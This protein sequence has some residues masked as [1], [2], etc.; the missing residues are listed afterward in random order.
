MGGG[1]GK[2][3]NALILFGVFRG[4]VFLMFRHSSGIHYGQTNVGASIS[5]NLDTRQT[6]VHTT[7]RSAHL[8]IIFVRG[9]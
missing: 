7:G 9:R 1:G 3:L 8:H 5:A 4:K 6:D 2:I